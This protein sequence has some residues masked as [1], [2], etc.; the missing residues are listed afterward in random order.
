MKILVDYR[1]APIRITDERI[2][3]VSGHAELAGLESAIH[4]ALTQP[5]RVVKS[6]ADPEARLYYRYRP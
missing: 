3:H 6:L 5:E 4:E 1:G 2:A